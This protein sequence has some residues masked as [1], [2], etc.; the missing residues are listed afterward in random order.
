M[1]IENQVV[2]SFHYRIC[3]E[4]G[5]E[6]ESSRGDVPNLYLYGAPGMLPGVIDALA[7]KQAGD[8]LS[9]TLTPEQAFGPRRDNAVE[10]VP[11]K[12]LRLADG[13]PVHR[14]VAAG[15]PVEVQTKQGVQQAT[16][17]K[18]GLKAADIDTNHPLAGMPVQVEIDIIAV[19]AATESEIAHGH[20]HGEGGHQ[21]H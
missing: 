17:V 1:I 10:R 5:V 13:R 21:H 3:D 4:Q 6:R 2:V 19:R 9:L 20:A 12:H 11:V 18:V 15:T 8:K 14:K 16:V 7:G